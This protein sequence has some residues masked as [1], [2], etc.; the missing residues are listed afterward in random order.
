MNGESHTPGKQHVRGQPLRKGRKTFPEKSAPSLGGPGFLRLHSGPCPPAPRRAFLGR[1][2][3]AVGCPLQTSPSACRPLGARPQA[4]D[5]G[6][7]RRKAD[8]VEAP[9]GLLPVRS[10]G[11][12]S[13]RQGRSSAR[14]TAARTG[15]A[16]RA[17]IPSR[18]G[19]RPARRRA[20]LCPRP[21]PRLCPD[22]SGQGPAPPLSANQ[23]R[24]SNP[25]APGRWGG[26][27]GRAPGSY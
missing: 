21:G 16:Q 2:V 17:R 9:S 12:A 13:P 26:G 4:P 25:G 3:R 18:L 11:C 1:P 8:G 22:L 20:A 23:N 5:P 19:T 27:V 15:V 7:R 24:A 14:S 6:L 10:A